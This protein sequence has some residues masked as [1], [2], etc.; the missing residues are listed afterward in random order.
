MDVRVNAAPMAF[1]EEEKYRTV[2]EF[3]IPVTISG[4]NEMSSEVVTT[5]YDIEILDQ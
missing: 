4:T 3:E 2:G 5:E 1:A